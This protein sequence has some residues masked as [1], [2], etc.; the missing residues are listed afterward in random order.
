MPYI[1]LPPCKTSGSTAFVHLSLTN[2]LV[3][4]S[5]DKFCTFPG[6]VVLPTALKVRLEDVADNFKAALNEKN[7]N[8]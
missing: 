6:G 5:I 1:T 8:S 4:G 2:L 7:L 3:T